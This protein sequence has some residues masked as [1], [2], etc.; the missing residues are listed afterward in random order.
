[1]AQLQHRRMGSIFGQTLYYTEA[2]MK[3]LK[4]EIHVTS[5]VF[6]KKKK[7]KLL[8]VTENPQAKQGSTI[9]NPQIKAF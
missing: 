4:S 3:T 2:H 7:L 6:S 1:M 9:K 5:T 8:Q